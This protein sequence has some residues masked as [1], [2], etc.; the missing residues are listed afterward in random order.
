VGN[1][2][3]FIVCEWFLLKSAKDPFLGVDPLDNMC[4][5]VSGIWNGLLSNLVYLRTCLAWWHRCH[6]GNP[7]G[8]IGE[9]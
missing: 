9:G 2:D 7:Q 4:H 8:A 3:T 1:V 6:Y 5:Y